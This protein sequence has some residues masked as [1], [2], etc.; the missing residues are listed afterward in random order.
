MESS[1]ELSRDPIFQAAN[2]VPS[3]VLF[4]ANSETCP[5]PEQLQRSHALLM[6]Y[7]DDPLCLFALATLY[8]EGAGCEASFS[9][10]LELFHLSATLGCAKSQNSLGGLYHNGRTDIAQPSMRFSKYGSLL[11]IEIVTVVLSH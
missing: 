1:S 3:L 5:S 8:M 9:R 7:P 11:D 2:T 4:L 6:E 10:A